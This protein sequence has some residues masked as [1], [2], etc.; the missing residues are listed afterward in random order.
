MTVKRSPSDQIQ[1]NVICFRC[2]DAEL[3]VILKSKAPK[4]AVGTFVKNI[5]L[6]EAELINER[7]KA[8]HQV[9]ARGV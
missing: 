9:H 6:N 4:Q 2:T 8:K 5:I 7:H 1:R 3:E